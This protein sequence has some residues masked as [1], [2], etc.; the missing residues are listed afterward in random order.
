MCRVDTTANQ[1]LH[2]DHALAQGQ[3]RIGGKVGV[4]RVPP[5]AGDG[6]LEVVGRR[7]DRA[8]GRRHRSGWQL[9]LQVHSD[10]CGWLMRREFG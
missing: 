10:H 4:S 5:T 1:M 6:D 7:V 2:G 3:D 9:V 8:R